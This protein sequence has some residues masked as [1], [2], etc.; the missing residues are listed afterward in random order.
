MTKSTYFSIA[1]FFVMSVFLLIK[2]NNDLQDVDKVK[3]AV[4]PT[5]YYLENILNENEY[6]IIKTTSTAESIELLKKEKVDLVF[7]GRTLKE[8]EGDF[9]FLPINEA[10]YSFLSNNSF[11]ISN[12]QFDDITF[13]TD[14]NKIQLEKDLSIKNIIEVRDVYE[15]IDEGIVITNWKNTDYNQ[16]EIVHVFDDKNERNP[17]SRQLRVFYQEKNKQMAQNAHNSIKK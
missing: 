2:L 14:L 12:E 10:G 13:F 17:L 8:S 16:S 6:Q 5:Y 15:Y 7:S 3:I 11:V 1:I 9:N 4:C